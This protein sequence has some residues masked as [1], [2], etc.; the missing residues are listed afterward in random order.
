MISLILSF[1]LN[2]SFFSQQQKIY[3][4]PV[5]FEHPDHLDV[6]VKVVDCGG[7]PTLL[8]I[9]F[10]ESPERKVITTSFKI[11]ISDEKGAS[12]EFKFPVR[13]YE[14]G[15]MTIYE[16]GTIDYDGASSLDWS[17]NNSSKK[18]TFEFD[19]VQ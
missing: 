3:Y 13:D 4:Q 6:T 2:L 8:L 12:E 7:T 19:Y 17:G 10:N 16:C 15:K 9:T 18:L 5:Q 11:K 14:F 1:F